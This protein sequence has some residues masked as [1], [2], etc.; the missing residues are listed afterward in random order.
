MHT[1]LARVPRTGG[2]GPRSQGPSESHAPADLLIKAWP[3]NTNL[4]VSLTR[5]HH[6]HSIDKIMRDIPEFKPRI[7][8]EE[9]IPANVTWMEEQGL[10]VD[11]S[12]EDTED[13]IVARID[14]LYR[15][16]GC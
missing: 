14:R 13:R 6:C 10:L 16:F 4:L 2:G 1:R 15:E 7:M 8:L 9:G 5:W 12:S 11:A 3:D